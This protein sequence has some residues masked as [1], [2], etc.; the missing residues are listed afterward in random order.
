MPG[1]PDDEQTERSEEPPRAWIQAR[2]RF[3][4]HCEGPGFSL[5]VRP[6]L[7]VLGMQPGRQDV[8]LDLHGLDRLAWPETSKQPQRW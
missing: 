5:I 1:G 3:F 4:H 7:R 8:G 2:V 6:R